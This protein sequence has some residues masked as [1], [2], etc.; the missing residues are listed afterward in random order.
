MNIPLPPQSD[1]EQQVRAALDED[2]GSGDITARLIPA[3]TNIN[4]RIIAREAGVLCGRA[5]AD[6]VFRQIDDSVSLHWIMSDGD[7][8]EEGATL[9]EIKGNARAILTA[10]RNALN[11][12]QTL[13]ATATQ[14][15]E[16]VSLVS[17]TA[18]KILAPQMIR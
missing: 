12:L 2:V 7:Q 3:T 1:I 10:E 14:T 18:V 5:W 15:A 16:L 8:I 4:A 6:E 9:L 13:S 17:H 11:F